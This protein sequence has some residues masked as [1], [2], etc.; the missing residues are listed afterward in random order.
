MYINSES[1]PRPI[2]RLHPLNTLYTNRTRISVST[3]SYISAHND[4]CYGQRCH[5][6][7]G[8]TSS[9]PVSRKHDNEWT[10][11]PQ[12]PV[13]R[14]P[15]QRLRIINRQRLYHLRTAILV[16]ATYCHELR[17]D[18]LRR[19]NVISTFASSRSHAN[20]PGSL[21]SRLSRMRVSFRRAP[22]SGGR[23]TCV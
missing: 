14:K 17:A 22:D 8:R 12:S 18:A 4:P 20:I 1:P 7:P 13:N 23:W 19:T 9:A 16:C 5:G 11:I 15:S 10:A 3:Y 6:R 21:P 2:P